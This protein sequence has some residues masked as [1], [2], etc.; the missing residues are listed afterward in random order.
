MLPKDSLQ[1]SF[2][3]RVS[4][5]T[6][7]GFDSAGVFIHENHV[8]RYYGIVSK[9]A[10]R[11]LRIAVPEAVPICE[12]T[13]PSPPRGSSQRKNQ[14]MLSSMMAAVEGLN[15]EERQQVLHATFKSA[16]S[17]GNGFL[18]RV[19]MA[20]MIRRVMPQA[21]HDQVGMM[22]NQIDKNGDAKVDYNEFIEYLMH[23]DNSG[24]AEDLRGALL[25]PQD[26]LRAAFRCWDKNGD[27]V[28]S[29]GELKRVL[30]VTCPSMSD[31]QIKGLCRHMDTNKD[32][33][34]D[35][36]EFVDFLFDAK[37]TAAG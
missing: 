34:I 9:M 21:S 32:G 30:K 3:W 11:A 7:L 37:K 27:G 28:I 16:D 24:L 13:G 26:A 18:S 14:M 15:D 22:M 1:E 2:F 23:R 6:R 29:Q 31:T 35:Y 4:P 25:T 33:S 36:G 20:A 17:N 10:D 12:Q 8:K 19:E 5:G